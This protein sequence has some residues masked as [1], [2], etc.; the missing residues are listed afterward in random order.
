MNDLPQRLDHLSNY[1]K[2][3][4]LGG[5]MLVEEAKRRIEALE[6]AL[7]EANRLLTVAYYAGVK[8]GFSRQEP[9][10]SLPNEVREFVAEFHGEDGGPLHKAARTAKTLLQKPE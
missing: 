10:A 8:L 2:G 5:P 9:D 1:I 7:T 6:A 3:T 4:V